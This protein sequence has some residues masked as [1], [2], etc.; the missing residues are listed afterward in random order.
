MH[1]NIQVSSFQARNSIENHV[2]NDASTFRDLLDQEIIMTAKNVMHDKLDYLRKR[3]VGNMF[4][5]TRRSMYEY[6]Y[7][8][9]YR[10]IL[11]VCEDFPQLHVQEC[12][13]NRTY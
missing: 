11:A 8:L 12:G 5:N 2:C 1:V 7:F 10:S 13:R 9:N 3:I 6:I 4:I